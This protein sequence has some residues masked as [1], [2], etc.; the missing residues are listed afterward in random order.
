MNKKSQEL[1]DLLE[2][3]ARESGLKV[4]GEIANL[5]TPEV[6]EAER[7]IER[8]LNE[9]TEIKRKFSNKK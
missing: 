7:E 1:R 9:L 3:T 6:K 8:I 5:K 2:D 4:K